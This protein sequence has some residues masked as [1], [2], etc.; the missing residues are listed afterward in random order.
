MA[1]LRQ[2]VLN[3]PRVEVSR[4]AL[5][6]RIYQ[7]TGFQREADFSEADLWA[8]TESALRNPGYSSNGNLSNS[9]TV[10]SFS[11]RTYTIKDG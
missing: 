1:S 2:Q 8:F 10:F 6:N 11:Q 9:T 3:D 5:F 4:Q 7:E